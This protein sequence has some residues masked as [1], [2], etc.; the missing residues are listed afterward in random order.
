[1]RSLRKGK[2]LKEKGTGLYSVDQPP[3]Q[4]QVLEELSI[5]LEVEEEADQVG[6]EVGLTRIPTPQEEDHQDHRDH[7]NQTQIRN[8]KEL[9]EMRPG[10]APQGQGKGKIKDPEVFNGERDKTRWRRPYPSWKG[11]I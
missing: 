4:Q 8:R 5:L 9:Q 3:R 11:T 2:A 6:L 1:M 7:Q 10:N